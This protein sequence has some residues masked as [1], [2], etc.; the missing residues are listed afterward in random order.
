MSTAVAPACQLPHVVILVS[1]LSGYFL[2]PLVI[3]SSAPAGASRLMSLTWEFSTFPS[4]GFLVRFHC[5]ENTLR[6]VFI[7]LDILCLVLWV[8]TSLGLVPV[9]EKTIAVS[10]SWRGGSGQAGGP[11]GEAPLRAMAPA[12][13]NLSDPAGVSGLQR[14]RCRIRHVL[15]RQVLPAGRGREEGCRLALLCRRQP[16]PRYAA[17]AGPRSPNPSAPRNS[18]GTALG[19][20]MRW[21][22]AP[23]RWA[24]PAH[25]S[26][27]DPGLYKLP[28]PAPS[29]WLCP[30]EHAQHQALSRCRLG[31][32]NPCT[33]PAGTLSPNSASRIK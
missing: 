19:T 9:L 20:E 15:L 22:P 7:L 30:R 1:S 29:L 5:S 25:G 24:P 3:L 21:Q 32:G 27:P 11:D 6:V 14:G 17:R 23:P 8:V 33:H 4:A 18:M 16:T 28:T 26:A 31:L 13:R 12:P 10:R 2:I